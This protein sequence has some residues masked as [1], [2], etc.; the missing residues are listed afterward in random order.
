[1]LQ[2][3]SSQIAIFVILLDILEFD[4]SS[5]STMAA[6]GYHLAELSLHYLS[7]QQNRVAREPGVILMLCIVV[8]VVTSSL[9]CSY[10][11]R[12]TRR[13]PQGHD[14]L[15]Y[16]AAKRIIS[17][18]LSRKCRDSIPAVESKVMRRCI[19]I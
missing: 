10:T 3:D 13:E 12:L 16:L 7:Q 8:I 6:L 14:S 2:T 4:Q 17:R 9:L 19:P 1:M 18:E 11:L 15:R 5:Y